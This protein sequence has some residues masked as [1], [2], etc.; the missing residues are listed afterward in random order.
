MTDDLAQ[1]LQ[2]LHLGRIAAILDAE[3]AHADLPW[4][5]NDVRLSGRRPLALG[6]CELLCRRSA[7][8][9]V[10]PPCCAWCTSVHTLCAGGG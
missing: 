3:L 10:R 2:T 7:P 8:A 1:L 5:P 6:D 9:P 4:L